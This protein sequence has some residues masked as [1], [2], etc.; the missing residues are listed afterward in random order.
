MTTELD[1]QNLDQEHEALD[2]QNAEEL[3]SDSEQEAEAGAEAEATDDDLDAGEEDE[4]PKRKGDLSI[5]LRK[6]RE[7][8][9][10]LERQ[11][12][13]LQVQ[14]EQAQQLL[15]SFTA[16]R[17]NYAQPQRPQ[18]SP[19]ERRQLLAEKLMEDPESVLRVYGE[20]I[21]NHVRSQF[22]ARL[23][24]ESEAVRL[25]EHIATQYATVNESSPE[26]VERLLETGR[27]TDGSLDREEIINA[28]EYVDNLIKV[29]ATK[30]QPK[31]VSKS[32]ASSTVGNA[33]A[34]AKP[35]KSR[36]QFLQEKAAELGSPSA[37]MNWFN[38]GG[39]GEVE[40]MYKNS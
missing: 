39:L 40:R 10:E 24:A 19:E 18:L 2:S 29:A 32:R 4:R 11:Q 23:K 31:A 38:S 33:G 16:Q 15:Q 8:K 37:F 7:A 17:Q 21:T 14:L 26:I 9:R 1:S 27:K 30:A 13:Q 34:V 6:E 12:Q 36:D 3:E 25:R 20:N 35:S 22:E 28:I 5:A